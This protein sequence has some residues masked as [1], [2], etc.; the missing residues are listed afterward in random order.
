MK[1]VYEFIN[2][3]YG[4]DDNF[5]IAAIDNKTNAIINYYHTK[6][7]FQKYYEQILLQNNMWNKSLYF[8]INSFKNKEEC[9]INE[10]NK[11]RK[12]KSNVSQIKS[13][14]FDFDEK[15]TSV[16]DCVNLI[17]TL[18][19][20]PTYILETSEMKFQVC[21]RLNDSNID[22]KEYELVNKTLAKKFNSDINVCSIEK[23]FRLPFTTNH[24][25]GFETTIKKID[26]EN[27]Y[28]FSMFK[29]KLN[30]FLTTDD[31]LTKYYNILKN[32]NIKNSQVSSKKPKEI[33]KSITKKT[34]TQNDTIDFNED[35]YLD[36]CL[37][38]KYQNL[39]KFNQNDASRADILYIIQRSK[40]IDEYAK[41]F[42]E[43]MTIR[44]VLDKPLKRDISSY[45]DDRAQFMC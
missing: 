20:N 21:Y 30:Q 26:V 28:D 40:V 44:K 41:I 1:N 12:T 34:P 6:S 36:E 33:T 19:M 42:D 25:N 3:Y 17:K 10:T 24:K 14:V 23:V 13:I 45:Y 8:S 35:E 4:E 38:A 5:F 31:N 11:P 15:K 2:W 29:D 9:E 22:F 7:S 39:L 18:K 37:I 32:K 27:S 16:E 43:I